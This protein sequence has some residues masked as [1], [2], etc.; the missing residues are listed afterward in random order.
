M[1]E[2]IPERPPEDLDAERAL[3]ATCCAPGMEADA[4]EVAFRLREDDFVH[5]V[6]R[7]LFRAMRELARHS[8]DINAITLKDALERAGDLSKVGDY[9]GLVEILSFD[10]VRRPSALAD[11]LTRKRMLRELIKIGAQLVRKA[12]SEDDT[13]EALVETAGRDLFQV[14][15]GQERGG[16]EHINPLGLEAHRNLL[17]RLDN[18]GGS[19]VLLGF[20]QLDRLTHGLQPG[21]LVVLAARPSVGKTA[22][23][24]N[25]LLRS[26]Y[27][28]GAHVAFFSLEM[29]KEEVFHRMLGCHARVNVRAALTAA[30]SP[31]VEGDSPPEPDYEENVRE[32]LEKAK[33]DLIQLPIYICD[34]AA[35]TVHEI[36][37]MVDRLCTQTGRHLDMLIID[38][39]QLIS[40]PPDSRGAKLSEVVRVAEISRALKLIAKDRKMPVVV[41]SQL[42]RE[43]DRGKGRKPKL[44]D[45]RD[46]GAIE[47][48]ADI[49]MLIHRKEEPPQG[50]GSPENYPDLIVAKHR[51]GATLTIPL[52]FSPEFSDFREIEDNRS[53]R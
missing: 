42:N 25:W 10:E 22:L 3:L 35:I 36:A 49:V 5:P 48:D 2:W 4:A 9:N 12:T 6:H 23:A 29:S 28:Y 11:I 20:E 30:S 37:S 40:S 39:L 46:S 15:Q 41:L 34:R 38:Y 16:L 14:A 47:Q 8:L 31:Q 21:N 27:H 32:R 19:G 13:P 1:D 43:P 45:L 18:K 51:N 7:A 17:D 53:G 24:L 44:S 33:D 26:S 52:W 50:G